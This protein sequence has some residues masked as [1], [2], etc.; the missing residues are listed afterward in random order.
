MDVAGYFCLKFSVP[1]WSPKEGEEKTIPSGEASRDPTG[2]AAKLAGE[3]G[4]RPSARLMRCI[5]ASKSQPF[6]GKGQWAA[7]VA[8]VSLK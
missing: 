6:C 4:A 7:Y 8:M 5:R 2:M 1:R 3:E